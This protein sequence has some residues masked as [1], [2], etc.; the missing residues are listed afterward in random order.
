LPR[1]RLTDAC[2]ASELRPMIRDVAGLEVLDIGCGDG[3]LALELVRA[4]ARVTGIDADAAM[5]GAAVAR[6]A[7]HDIRLVQGRIETLPFPMPGSTS[8]LP[9]PCCASCVRRDRLAGYGAR[10]RP[11]GRLVVG[12]LGRSR[13]W[14]LRRR[15]RGR[16]G[17]RLWHSATFHSAGQSRRAAEAAGLAVQAMR[18][19]RME[20][21]MVNRSMMAHPMQLH[22]HHSRL[23]RWPG[24]A[25]RAPCAIPSTC[26]RWVALPSPSMPAS[27]R[28]GCC[29]ATTCRI[30][31]PA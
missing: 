4:D 8:S 18:G 5:L 25:F 21:A 16:L 10:P 2:E 26:R 14:A 6:V 19:E 30:W 11:G 20:I 17:S 31:R 7:E 29:T 22:G 27:R 1:G 15:I 9:S 12:E 3:A 23:S 28:P 24:S 13:P